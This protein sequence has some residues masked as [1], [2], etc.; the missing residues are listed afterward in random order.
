MMSKVHTIELDDPVPYDEK[1]IGTIYKR[2]SDKDYTEIPR[3]YPLG[4]SKEE[5]WKVY[6]DVGVAREHWTNVLGELI[7]YPKLRHGCKQA[8]LDKIPDNLDLVIDGNFD[9][10]EIVLGNAID[11]YIRQNYLEDGNDEQN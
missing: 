6:I 5:R 9:I 1:P 8:G 10:V 11:D 2:Y 7:D 4:M 3:K